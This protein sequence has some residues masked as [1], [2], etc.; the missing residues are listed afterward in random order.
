MTNLTAAEINSLTSAITGVEAG[1]VANKAAAESRFRRAA[2]AHGI[3][4]DAILS[5]STGFDAGRALEA[6]K[7]AAATDLE[8]EKAAAAARDARVMQA[9]ATMVSPGLARL[10][11][12][13]KAEELRQQAIADGEA[14]IRGEDPFAKTRKGRAALAVLEAEAPAPEAVKVKKTRAAKPKAEKTEGRAPRVSA[15]ETAVISAV[16]ANPKKPGSRAYERFS[17]YAAGQ[18]VKDFIAACIKAGFAEREARADIS[19]DRRKGFITV[20]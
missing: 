1:R 2:A 20:A 13:P 19:W 9:A 12:H 18:S 15:S 14:V 5:C 3:D 11:A 16:C 17:L 6:A 10:R 4:A 8:A 7:Q